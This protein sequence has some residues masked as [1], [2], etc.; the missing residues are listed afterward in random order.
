VPDRKWLSSDHLVAPP[1]IVEDRWWLN[2]RV[3]PFLDTDSQVFG[4]KKVFL[5]DRKLP[6]SESDLLGAETAVVSS[7]ASS[8]PAIQGIST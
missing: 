5:I 4:R 6:K 2:G 1:W 8:S 7:L 3:S